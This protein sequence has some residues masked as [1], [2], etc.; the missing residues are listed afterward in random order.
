VTDTE[1]LDALD[2]IARFEVNEALW[3][4]IPSTDQLD[5]RVARNNMTIRDMMVHVLKVGVWRNDR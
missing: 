4:L 1:I 2:K 3:W 5:L